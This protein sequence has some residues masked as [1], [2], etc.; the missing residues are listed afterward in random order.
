MNLV[1][2]S[3]RAPRAAVRHRY[4]RIIAHDIVTVA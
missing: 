2:A 1:G 4:N 3:R